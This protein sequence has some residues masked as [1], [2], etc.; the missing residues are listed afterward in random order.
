MLN[1]SI[2]P[3]KFRTFVSQTLGFKKTQLTDSSIV[4]FD[5]ERVI[6]M[7]ALA[8][9]IFVLAEYAKSYFDKLEV[10]PIP[11]QVMLTQTLLKRLSSG[12]SGDK[13]N[14]T[15]DEEY[16]HITGAPTD[17]KVNEKLEA[18][19]Q[20]KMAPY[21]YKATEVG[22]VPYKTQE[23]KI[24]KFLYHVQV[25]TDVFAGALPNEV[26]IIFDGK[27]LKLDFSDTMGSRERPVPI[28]ATQGELKPAE[29]YFNFEVIQQLVSL[30]TG[31][32]WMSV[33]DSCVCL[34]QVNK[35]YS[36]SYVF[37]SKIGSGQ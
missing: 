5:G 21:A 13:I 22:L 1:I 37:A 3:E 18:I 10:N 16:W 24:M 8:P 23:D 14:I 31:N 9:D 15:T 36:L 33:N 29:V 17:D 27:A 11:T 6:V 7:C 25:P 32:I 34:G 28:I 2:E 35:D 30:F 26:K 19:N 12:F 20:D 4:T